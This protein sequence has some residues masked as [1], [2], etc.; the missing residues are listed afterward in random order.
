MFL[1]ADWTVLAPVGG[2]AI[3]ESFELSFHP[4]RLQIDAKVGRRI[5]EY[6]WPDRKQRIMEVEDA[7]SQSPFPQIQVAKSPV[8]PVPSRSSLDSPRTL[9]NFRNAGDLNGN[10]LVLPL[11]RLGTSRS[12]TDLRSTRDY[13]FLF[14][15]N[16][17]SDSINNVPS[18]PLLDQPFLTASNDS[19]ADV[20]IRKAGDAAEMKTRSSQKSFVLVR[21]SRQVGPLHSISLLS[22]VFAQSQPSAK[23]C[24]GRLLRVP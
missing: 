24:K 21:V 7:G 23:H 9:H 19:D 3:Y 12:F 10:K 4:L 5:M 14:Q 20:L 11:R 13:T 1:L 6:L 8:S 18:A 2:I 16:Q 17:S 22:F 15:R